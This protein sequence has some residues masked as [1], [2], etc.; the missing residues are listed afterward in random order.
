MREDAQGIEVVGIAVV[1]NEDSTR[2]VERLLIQIMGLLE[3]SPAS[4]AWKLD[5]VPFGQSCL[6]QDKLLMPQLY[7]RPS[8][9]A[10][11][12]VQ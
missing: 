12:V 1:E 6:V 7:Y 3:Q 2:R 10:Y 5:T 4:D 9:N 11:R 8:S